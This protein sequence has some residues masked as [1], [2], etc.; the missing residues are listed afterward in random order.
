MK[1]DYV[2]QFVMAYGG[3]RGAISFALVVLLDETVYSERRLLIT[4][5]IAVTYVTNFFLV[6]IIAFPFFCS[7]QSIWLLL[8]LKDCVLKNIEESYTVIESYY[9]YAMLN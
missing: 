4:T 1:L 9:K 3:L 2:D 7:C 8:P 5:T 6:I